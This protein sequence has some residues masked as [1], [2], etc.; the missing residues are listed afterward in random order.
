MGGYTRKDKIWNDY[1]WEDIGVI[2]IKGN[3]VKTD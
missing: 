3:D 2:S 1:I